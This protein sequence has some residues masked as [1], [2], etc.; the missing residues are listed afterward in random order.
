MDSIGVRELRQDASGVLRRVAAG[1][2]LIVT[3]RGRPVARL[4]PIE[5]RG[6]QDLIAAGLVRMP[7]RSMRDAPPPIKL[8]PGTMTPSEALEAARADER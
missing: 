2:S 3:H 4:S 1:E 8:P 7:K 5:S 6:L